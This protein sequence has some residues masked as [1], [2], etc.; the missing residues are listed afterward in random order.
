M[1]KKESM[2]MYTA[3][4]L[5]LSFER[6]KIFNPWCSNSKANNDEWRSG[7]NSLILFCSFEHISINAG[8]TS[9]NTA[10]T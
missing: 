4:R 9:I 5:T 8:Q 10:H 3:A 1:L 6:V 7:D 2:D